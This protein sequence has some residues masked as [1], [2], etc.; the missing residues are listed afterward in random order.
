M[1]PGR[2][3][4][5]LKTCSTLQRDTYS[6]NSGQGEGQKGDITELT[7]SAWAFRGDSILLTR[8]KWKDQT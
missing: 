8:A 1:L 4:E 5:E 7:S 2:K 6:L 3:E